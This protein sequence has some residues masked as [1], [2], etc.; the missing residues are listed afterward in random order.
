MNQIRAVSY[1]RAW[2]RA[3]YSSMIACG[4]TRLYRSLI[5]YAESIWT[6]M[7]PLWEGCFVTYSTVFPTAIKAAKFR[8]HAM[9]AKSSI[10][11]LYGSKTYSGGVLQHR[12]ARVFRDRTR[13]EMLPKP[14]N[15][16]SP[17]QLTYRWRESTDMQQLSPGCLCT[18]PSSTGFEGYQVEEKAIRVG[19][20]SVVPIPKETW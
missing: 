5:N 2:K 18:S 15:S 4:L 20:H 1:Y 7:V 3:G 11:L 16:T 17:T 19:S 10:L 6:N 14:W 9:T 12:F 8:H 13:F